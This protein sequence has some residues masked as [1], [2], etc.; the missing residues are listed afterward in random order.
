MIRRSSTTNL[1]RKLLVAAASVACMLAAPANAQSSDYPKQPIK[2]IV[3]YPPGGSGDITGRIVADML[4][5][6]LNTA[7]VVENVGGAGGSIGAQRVVSA[8]PDGYT[9]L[10]GA[11][12]EIAINTLTNPSLKYD[13]INDLTHIGLI[14]SQ[15]LVLVANPKSNIKTI[16][17]FVRKAK[18]SPESLAYGTSGIGTSFH[19]VGELIN[20]S[21]DIAM[22]HVPY[23]GAAP[24]T[25]D[26]LGGQIELGIVV[27]SSAL[28]HIKDGRL[29]AV[30][31]TELE[32]SASTPDIPALA[33][34]DSLKG[35]NMGNWYTFAAP[36]GTPDDVIAKLQAA[37][38]AGLSD[39][40]VRKRLEDA[41]SRPFNGT[42][43]V[44]DF[45][46]KE[47]AKFKEIVSFA[48]LKK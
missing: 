24:L 5:K 36:K 4:S 22:L 11:N 12:N 3:G 10:V 20:H 15:P 34:H 25:T 23:R 45:L 37:L 48:D 13:G 33:E 29:I 17:D 21:A 35:F 16:D 32:R 44:N 47:S 30:G 41:G 40:E 42:E 28:P 38:R 6:Q 26:L 7:V 39:P 14:N 31:T 27:L 19:L 46:A 1:R 43:D 18:E 8:Q 2:I 9:L